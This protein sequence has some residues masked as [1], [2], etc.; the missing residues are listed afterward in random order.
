VIT[1]VIA[2]YPAASCDTVLVHY[3]EWFREDR[4]LNRWIYGWLAYI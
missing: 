2:N 1:P 3:P 4:M